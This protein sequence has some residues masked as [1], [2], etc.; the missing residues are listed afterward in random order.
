MSVGRPWG[1]HG[2][3]VCCKSVAHG[4]SVGHPWVARGLLMGFPWVFRGLSTGR[5]W[6]VCELPMGCPRVADGLSVV[7]GV[8]M[9]CSG[10][11]CVQLVPMGFRWIAR[12]V[13]VGRPRVARGAPMRIVSYGMPM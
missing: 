4:L 5:P 3:Y 11:P 8:P 6:V 9:E 2:V 7:R 12:R 10:F 1:P 13:S